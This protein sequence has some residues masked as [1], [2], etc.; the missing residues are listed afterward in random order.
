VDAQTL[1]DRLPELVSRLR[2]DLEETGGANERSIMLDY[3]PAECLRL[4]REVLDVP[5]EREEL[6]VEQLRAAGTAFLDGD[7]AALLTLCPELADDG[8]GDDLVA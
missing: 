8:E 4:L 7:E 2:V 1:Q 6:R 3:S 5:S